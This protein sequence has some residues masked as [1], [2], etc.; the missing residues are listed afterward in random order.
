MDCADVC[1]AT[2]GGDKPPGVLRRQRQQAFSAGPNHDG[3]LAGA[4]D[5]SMAGLVYLGPDDS[6]PPSR[7]IRESQGHELGVGSPILLGRR[8]RSSWER[9]SRSVDRRRLAADPPQTGGPPASPRRG[10]S[11][12]HP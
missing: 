7:G 9:S 2:I 4:T 6:A 5:R 12:A 11:L 3:I 10:T 8:C 1:A